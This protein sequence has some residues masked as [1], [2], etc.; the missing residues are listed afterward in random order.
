MSIAREAYLEAKS[1]SVSA[2]RLAT[3]DIHKE[4]RHE[5][6]IPR[7]WYFANPLVK[8]KFPSCTSWKRISESRV[9]IEFPVKVWQKWDFV[10]HQRKELWRFIS[11]KGK[12]HG[13]TAVIIMNHHRFDGAFISLIFHSGRCGCY[14]LQV[15]RVIPF[16]RTNKS[17]VETRCLINYIAH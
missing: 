7:K 2:A 13:D 1:E 17:I 5:I 10:L 12:A 11:I 15:N 16:K 9:L 6:L 3:L 4:V 8:L 14:F